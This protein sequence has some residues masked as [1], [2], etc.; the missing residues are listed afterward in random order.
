MDPLWWLLGLA[1]GF[2]AILLARFVPQQAGS[3]MPA[4][5]TAGG[6]FLAGALLGAM[7][8]DR[9]WRWAFACV[10][11]LPLHDAVQLAAD[12]R[13]ISISSTLVFSHL[14]AQA[15]LYGYFLVIAFVGAGMGASL[16]ARR[17]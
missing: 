4:V 11:S 17:M 1:A 12:P 7:K 6:I 14:A 16:S 3:F 5:V 9:P 8:A 13:Y 10:L 2:A 15:P